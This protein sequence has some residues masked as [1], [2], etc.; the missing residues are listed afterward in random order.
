MT[1]CDFIRLHDGLADLDQIVPFA[2]NEPKA[3]NWNSIKV[4][5]SIFVPNC[6]DTDAVSPQL[7]Y[8]TFTSTGMNFNTILIPFDDYDYFNVNL[9]RLS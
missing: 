6:P 5:D 4:A 7:A 3:I 1:H 2:D 8:L 9:F